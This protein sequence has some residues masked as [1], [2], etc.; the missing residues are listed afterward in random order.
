MFSICISKLVAGPFPVNCR[1]IHLS[2]FKSELIF[3]ICLLSVVLS[4]PNAFAEPKAN[5]TREIV[6]P[7]G[8]ALGNDKGQITSFFKSYKCLAADVML[9]NGISAYSFECT[10]SLHV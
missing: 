10:T 3:G 2:I 6:L 5:S 7:F 9:E 1:S 8:F 4:P